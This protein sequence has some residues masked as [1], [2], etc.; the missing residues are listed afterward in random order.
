MSSGKQLRLRRVI[1]VDGRTV[2]V[3]VDHSLTLGPAEG[4]GDVPA[5]L[6]TLAGGGPDAVIAQRGPVSAG[7]WPAGAATV[8]AII[9][10]SGAT[11]LSPESHVK[12][13]VCGVEAALRL[14]ADAVS[15]HVSLGTGNERDNR[16]LAH[17]GAVADQCTAWGLPLLAMMYVYGA[18]AERPGAVAHAARVGAD[19]G[20]DIVKV[21]HTADLAAVVRSSYVPI[22]VAG[23]TPAADGGRRLLRVVERS[24]ADGAAGVCV[25]RGV[26]QHRRPA[27][28][29]AALRAVVHDGMDA[30]L[31]YR[32]LT[33][34]ESTCPTS[35][36]T[37]PPATRPPSPVFSGTRR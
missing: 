24:I 2:I 11:E 20:A 22:V 8:G 4:L 6:Q 31:A 16:A 30:E 1:G 17:L 36:A 21:N 3:P 32:L 26:F 13:P 25:G 34:K 10:L 15:V 28:M 35:G 33:E 12:V 29:L 14:G 23:G 5:A 9:H 37:S 7:V 27:A 18:A 19:L